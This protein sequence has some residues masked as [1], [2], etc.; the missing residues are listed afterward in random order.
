MPGETGSVVVIFDRDEEDERFPF[1]MTWHGEHHQESDMAFYATDPAAQVVGPGILR[2]T[3]GGFLL[4]HPP[5]R[6][7]D[8]WS[9]PDYRFA[10]DKPE[11]LLAAAIDYS[12][13]ALV[14]HV[15]GRRPSEAMRRR[16]ASQAKRILH[17]PLGALSPATLSKVRVVHLLAGHD[18]RTI[19]RDYIW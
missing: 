4:V 10:R 18:K 1:R 7:W 17:V 9:D 16:A 3:Y 15:G 11:A 12:L 14:V 19:A 8:I 5:G 6:L 2:A 13:G